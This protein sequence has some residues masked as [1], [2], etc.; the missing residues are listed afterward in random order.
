MGRCGRWGLG[1]IVSVRVCGS[2]AGV[3]LSH[4][5]KICIL[6]L[7]LSLSDLTYIRCVYLFSTCPYFLSKYLIIIILYYFLCLINVLLFMLLSILVL[8]SRVRIILGY[9][10]CDCGFVSKSG[11]LLRLRLM[12]LVEGGMLI[13]IVRL[14]MNISAQTSPV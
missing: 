7:F 5:C 12:G 8:I 2:L 4:R 11:G 13:F 10:G 3:G 1:I 6:G 14:I 9:F